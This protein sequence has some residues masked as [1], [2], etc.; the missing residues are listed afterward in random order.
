MDTFTNRPLRFGVFELDVRA[1]ELRRSGRRVALQPQPLE[2]LRTLLER[3]GELVTREELRRRVWKNGANIDFD[4]SLNK[5]IVKLRDALGDDA[6][7]PRYIETLPRHGYRFIPSPDL[8]DQVHAESREASTADAQ[9][10]VPP[11]PVPAVGEVP[12]WRSGRWITISTAVT[13]LLALTAMAL[14]VNSRRPAVTSP[15]EYEPLTDVTDSATAPALSPDGRMLAFIR[16]GAPFLSSG[17][18]WLKFLPD[19]ES[20]Q[21]THSSVPVFAPTF[22]P[23]GTHVAYTSATGDWDTWLVG[24]TGGEPTRLLGNASGLTYIG[25]HE[26]LYSEVKSGIHL[27]VVTSLDDRSHRR[28]VYLPAHERGMAHYSYLSP[29]RQ[30]VL[31][32]EMTGAGEFQRCRLVPFAG[33]TP[34]KLVGPAGSCTSAAWSVDGRWMY[35]GAKVAGRS[36]LW[37]QRYPDGHPE[38][39]TFGPTEEETV[40]VDSRSGALLT[41]VGSERSSIWMHDAKGERALTTDSY[42]WQPWLSPD[43][44]RVYFLVAPRSTETVELWRMSIASGRR[45]VVLSGLAFGGLDD[46]DISDDERHVAFTT[47]NAGVSEIWVAPLD[48]RS[49]PR[50]LVHGGDTPKFDQRGSVWFRRVGEHANFLQRVSVDG[51]TDRRMLDTPILN[52]QA[53]APEGD[54][55]VL[56]LP[57]ASSRAPGTWLV[58]PTGGAPYLVYEDWTPARWSRDGKL[59]YVGVGLFGTMNALGIGNRE[60]Q[61]AGSTSV[62]VPMETAILRIGS[63][64]SLIAPAIPAQLIPHF[65]ESLSVGSDPAV[66]AYVRTEPR[67]NIYRIP[68]H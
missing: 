62:H 5:A 15:V 24:V 59:L 50:L 30:S 3:P 2:I 58:S 16:D 21:L 51:G 17:Q 52:L 4:R 44:R 34:G 20:V 53:V 68:L 66:Y 22:T 26:V 12:R 41:S 42:V 60:P 36:H 54:R 63:N 8:H 32:V 47:K 9:P 45:E 1:G 40:T 19:G 13:L 65:L 6:D 25:P 18:I 38:Q 61:A 43:S 7:S 56:F 23:D 55:V 14:L 49:P 27:G 28:E 64:G 29:D 48:R 67:R 46:Y 35:F 10:S 37:R 31:I 33:G 39:I 11:T 57:P